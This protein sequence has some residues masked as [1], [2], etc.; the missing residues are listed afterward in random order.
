MLAVNP[1]ISQ[2]RGFWRFVTHS[3]WLT[4]FHFWGCFSS[5]V[6]GFSQSWSRQVGDRH[7]NNP[8][9]SNPF[10]SQAAGRIQLA[11]APD[12]WRSW[13]AARN[14]RLN[15]SED[16]DDTRKSMVCL[17]TK[18]L[19]LAGQSMLLSLSNNFSY[20]QL[21]WD[22]KKTAGIKSVGHPLATSE[23]RHQEGLGGPNTLKQRASGAFSVAQTRFQLPSAKYDCSEGTIRKWI[24]NPD[25]Y[26]R[27]TVELWAGSESHMAISDVIDD[28]AIKTS[29]L[30]GNFPASHI[31]WPLRVSQIYP[32][33][34]WE[35]PRTER[36]LPPALLHNSLPVALEPQAKIYS[37]SWATAIYKYCKII[38]I[39]QDSI[40]KHLNHPLHIL[41]E[42]LKIPLSHL[43]ILVGW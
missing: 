9:M 42:P 43:I 7:L 6:L 25:Q 35:L 31:W 16:G 33:S 8:S 37:Y 1:W 5:A 34:V 38:K 17:S 26:V 12:P 28:F 22:R 39:Y 19:V 40:W 36:D 24:V 32:S 11:P 13:D 18:I 2:R 3:L 21:P 30:F 15:N 20:S 41:N 14:R 23:V 10:G 4:V 29:I 27:Y